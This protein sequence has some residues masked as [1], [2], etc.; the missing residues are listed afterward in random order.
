L[1]LWDR[2]ILT[3]WLAICNL[4][5]NS[6]WNPIVRVDFLMMHMALMKYLY[7]VIVDDHFDCGLSST[8]MDEGFEVWFKGRID[9]G[10]SNGPQMKMMLPVCNEKKWTMYVRVVMK[11]EIRGIE[12][13]A[14]MVSQNDVGDKSS[15][16]P[17]LTEVVDEQGLECGIVLMQSS[18]ES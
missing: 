4:G 3:H 14:R 8:L 17:M 13:V 18:Q 10:L 16:S 2:I 11:L 15:R 1:R 5:W 6:F 7:F 9:I 12:L